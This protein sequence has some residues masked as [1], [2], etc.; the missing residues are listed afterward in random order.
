MDNDQLTS[1]DSVIIS[2]L[3]NSSQSKSDIDGFKFEAFESS[4]AVIDTL[5]KAGYSAINAFLKVHNISPVNIIPYFEGLLDLQ[6]Q[7]ENVAFSGP[8][9]WDS[10]YSIR[11]LNTASSNSLY[12]WEI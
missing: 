4:A 1:I 9:K 10:C 6:T 12:G 3:N 11:Q 5:P 8:Y 7:I 2:A